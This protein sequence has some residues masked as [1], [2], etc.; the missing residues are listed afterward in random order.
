M[1]NYTLCVKLH[2]KCVEYNY[3]GV[4]V[5]FSMESFPSFEKFY[6]Y[7]GGGVG[8]NYEACLDGNFLKSESQLSYLLMGTSLFNRCLDLD[9][10][11]VKSFT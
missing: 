8:D 4:P 9:V 3:T 5:A 7:T 2:L 6:K 10:S 1:L 11:D